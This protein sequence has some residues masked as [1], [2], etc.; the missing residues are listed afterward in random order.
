MAGAVVVPVLTVVLAVGF[1]PD[2]PATGP[3][4]A[5]A[6]VLRDGSRVTENFAGREGGGIFTAGIFGGAATLTVK[7]SRIDANIAQLRGGGVFNAAIF[8]DAT[9]SMTVDDDSR[10]SRNQALGS[11]SPLI[12]A[13]G[14]GIYN[15]AITGTTSVTGA[16]TRVVR[17]NT[18]TNCFG[19]ATC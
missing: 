1:L 11:T 2:P 18:P 7:D 6:V 16:T 12:D 9:A 19:V 8:G 10:I 3:G 4:S 17:N 13:G 15:L 14:G 5:S